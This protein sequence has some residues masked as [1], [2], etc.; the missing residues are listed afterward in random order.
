MKPTYSPT[1]ED[2]AVLATDQAMVPVR[3]ELLG[4]LLTPVA[5]AARLFPSMR[6]PFLL[7]SAEGG[8]SIGRYSYLGGN[9]FLE[10]VGTQS[11]IVTRLPDGEEHERP[12]DPVAVLGGLDARYRAASVPGC[13]PFAGGAVGYIGYDAARWVEDLPDANAGDTPWCWFGYYDTLIAF[14]HL[15]HRVQVVGNAHVTDCQSSEALREA[16]EEACRRIDE[17]L[18]LLGGADVPMTRL[19]VVAPDSAPPLTASSDLS[20]P[21]FSRAVDLVKSHI[22]A[23]DVFQLVLSRAMQCEVSADPVTV[24]RA[25]RAVNPSPYMYCFDTGEGWVVG[26]SPEML[27]RV[28]GD[29]VETRPIAGTRRRDPDPVV[30]EGLARE[31]LADAKECAEHLMLVDLGRND[32]GRVARYG[33]V[34]VPVF[35]TVERYSHVMHI[36]SSVRGRLRDGVTALEALFASFPAGTVSGAPK[37]RAMEIIDGLERSPRG[38]YAGA[39]FYSDFAGNMNS[40]IAIRTIV[41]RDGVATVRAGAGIVMDSN[42]AREFEET[43]EKAAAPLQALAWA[44]SAVRATEKKQ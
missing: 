6:R 31:L 25:L 8:E 35:M 10:V 33:E 14:D 40:C 38:V 34:E 37:I 42:A 21:E 29:H 39:V 19:D 24:Y 43:A 22:Q 3:V 28:S 16:Y 7:E 1:F 20:E 15:R 26:S 12:G 18:R 9:P 17:S 41:M 13:P 36:V 32:V 4:D 5:A 23:G 11:G 30:D 44:E 2:F 27:V